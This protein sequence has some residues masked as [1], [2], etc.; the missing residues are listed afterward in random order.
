MKVR[1]NLAT[2]PLEGGR[3]FAFAAAA[4]GAVAVIAFIFLAT[5]AYNVSREERQ[6]K[7]DLGQI[8]AQIADLDRQRSELELYFNDPAVLKVRDRAAFLNGLIEERSFPWTRIFMD[9][10]NLLPEGVRVV[11]ISPKLAGDHIEL[12][13]VTGAVS[14][15][16]KLKFLR[17]LETSR[18]F[19]RI[20]VMSETRPEH[21]DD[22]DQVYLELVAWYEAS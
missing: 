21:K 14:D 3:R 15:E 20:Q 22:S 5:H 11:S 4:I 16:A 18:S 17:T 10:E 6:E 12:H 13:L 1:L 19:S 7:A 8:Q 9:L 2:E